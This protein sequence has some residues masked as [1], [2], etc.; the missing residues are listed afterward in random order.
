MESFRV[1]YFIVIVDTAI[2]SLTSR[3]EQLKT[4][5]KLFGF[6]LNSDNLKSLNDN[7][8]HKHCTTFA[9]SFFS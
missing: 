6:L 9:Q 2:A 3:F 5:E 7:D 1:N 4:F 8:L